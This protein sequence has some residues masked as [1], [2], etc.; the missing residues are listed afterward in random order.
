MSDT[1]YVHAWTL[2]H[3]IDGDLWIA[4]R[5]QATQVLRAASARLEAGRADDAPGILRG[6]DGLGLPHVSPECIAFN[7]STF[8]GEAGDPF[9]LER[10]ATTG[11][12]MRPGAPMVGRAVRRCDTRGK[13]YDLA[14]CSLLLL[15]RLHLGDGMR[16]GSSS[17]LRGGWRA[18]A[19]VLREATGDATELA[20]NEQGLIT[21]HAGPLP[22]RHTRARNSA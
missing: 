22:G 2:P 15:A 17:D 16:L 11:I 10:F 9:F 12:V 7:G 18:A 8:R 6:P 13:P 4:L 1:P 3:E 14:V 20:Q 5:F 19:D 21:C